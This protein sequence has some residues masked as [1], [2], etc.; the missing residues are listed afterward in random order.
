MKITMVIRSLVGGG[1]E[2]VL[3]L[4]AEGLAKRGHQVTVIT[5]NRRDND[6]YK[7]SKTIKRFEL[8]EVF[9]GTKHPVAL[10][11]NY[12]IISGLRKLLS[13][14]KPDV[15]I[16]F[17]HMVNLRVILSLFG[18]KIPLIITEHTNPKKSKL[19]LVW[20]GIRRLLYPQADLLVVVSEGVKSGFHWMLRNKVIYNPVEITTPNNTASRKMVNSAQPKVIGAM[21]R[22][23]Y[24]KGFDI[25]I[26]AFAPIAAKYPE[27]NLI[28][29]GEGEE[30]EALDQQVK[31][32]KLQDRISL[33]GFVDNPMVQMAIMSIFVVSSRW[34]GYCLVLAEAMAV[35]LPVISFNCPSGPSELITNNVDGLLIEKGNV[36]KLT[37][38]METLITDEHRRKILG[39]RASK[40]VERFSLARILDQWE[41]TIKKLTQKK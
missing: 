15:I 9:H 40:S 34:E 32:A 3:V 41:K 16:S 7:L 38:S 28:I 17:V 1:A 19:P 23:C 11:R 39:L 22:L 6:A 36:E 4:L 2:R 13:D 20:R 33:P 35:G 14:N 25:L 31:V 37:Q 30:R 21:G 27:W 18:T 10:N 5:L 12:Q 26:K 29:F 8:S 24:V